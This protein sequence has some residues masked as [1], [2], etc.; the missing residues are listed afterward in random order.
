MTKERY[1]ILK[2][3]SDAEGGMQYHLRVFG[4]FIARREGYVSHRDI[5]AVHYY[6]CTKFNW[7]P[8]TVRAMSFQDIGFLLEEEMRGWTLPPEAMP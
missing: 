2:Q 6:L 4:D 7:T 8:A 1:S 5:D 3:L